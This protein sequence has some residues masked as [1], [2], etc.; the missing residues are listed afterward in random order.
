MTE[1]KWHTEWHIPDS[2]VYHGLATLPSWDWR[3][4]IPREYLPVFYIAMYAKFIENLLSNPNFS[5]ETMMKGVDNLTPQS[6]SNLGIGVVSK[7]NEVYIRQKIAKKA[8]DIIMW[9]KKI[10]SL[11]Q[12]MSALTLTNTLMGN[13]GFKVVI[14]TFMRVNK[15]IDITDTLKD[16]LPIFSESMTKKARKL[17]ERYSVLKKHHESYMLQK[18][19][20]S[21]KT[22]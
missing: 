3:N 12:L 17:L 1:K 11:E 19:T 16:P 6:K 22:L 7:E 8:Y 9:N 2:S 18:K 21:L 4:R 20:L 14:D 15:E 5:I 10:D 13:G